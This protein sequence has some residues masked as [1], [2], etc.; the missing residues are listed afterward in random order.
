L[1]KIDGEKESEG[2]DTEGSEKRMYEERRK[3]R[4]VT[5]KMG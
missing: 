5:V 1:E 4:G 2:I 3:Y